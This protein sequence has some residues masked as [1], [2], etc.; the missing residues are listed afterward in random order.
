MNK[1]LFKA[2]KEER[3]II[4]FFSIIKENKIDGNIR[5]AFESLGHNPRIVNAFHKWFIDYMKGKKLWDIFEKEMARQ[6]RKINLSHI[7]AIIDYSLTWD[8]TKQGFAFWQRQ[9]KMWKQTVYKELSNYLSVIKKQ[10]L[11]K[12]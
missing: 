8:A 3:S 6:N 12:K 5:L 1:T 9:N 10:K 7:D 2:L 4:P 11:Q